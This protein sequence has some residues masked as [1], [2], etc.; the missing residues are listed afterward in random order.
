MVNPLQ[1]I[2]G[3][4]LRPTITFAEAKDDP[5]DSVSVP[6]LLIA[7]LGLLVKLPGSQTILEF[8]A[9][10]TFLTALAGA[11]AG[12]GMLAI[13]TRIAGKRQTL[14]PAA[15]VFLSAI[16]PLL[17]CNLLVNAMLLSGYLGFSPARAVAG[18]S[19]IFM[20]LVC[21]WTIVLLVIGLE[22]L[23]GMPAPRAALCSG[24]ALAAT[25]LAVLAMTLP[26]A[27]ILAISE[28][29]LLTKLQLFPVVMV[30][31]FGCYGILEE[32]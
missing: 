32:L 7:L 16:I 3:M 11:L 9:L 31:I 18:I 10:F 4:I 29:G 30:G 21:I 19:W 27:G 14:W 1:R 20:I 2:T 12:T 5:L 25:F 26:V 28:P 6:Y 23:F 24:A 22:V 15:R 13:I 17:L 8:E